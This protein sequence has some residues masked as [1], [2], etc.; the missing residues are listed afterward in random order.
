MSGTNKHTRTHTR[1]H[2]NT[3]RDAE[4]RTSR[5]RDT[6]LTVRVSSVSAFC[7]LF[8]L[9]CPAFSATYPFGLSG[10]PQLGPALLKSLYNV[11]DRLVATDSSVT[12]LGIGSLQVPGDGGFY[13]PNDVALFWKHNNLMGTPN[14]TWV[15]TERPEAAH[16]P[17]C[18]CDRAKR[19]DAMLTQP[20]SSV[21][22]RF[23]IRGFLICSLVCCSC[24]RLISLFRLW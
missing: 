12:K 11:P 7:F 17:P 14:T 21:A 24:C 1:T 8:S 3:A 6:T 9:C 18:S 19:R 15:T 22:S 23:L 16:T 2:T 10:M 13:D 5:L 20:R 4:W